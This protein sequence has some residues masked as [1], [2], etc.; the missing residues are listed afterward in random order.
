MLPSHTTTTT[1][2]TTAS[3]SD[4]AATPVVSAAAMQTAH[5]GH[6]S[7]PRSGHDD[8][9]AHHLSKHPTSA[10]VDKATT[11]DNTA[12]PPT[13]PPPPPLEPHSSRLPDFLY[14]LSFCPPLPNPFL[15][16]LAF[17]THPG[18]LYLVG[19]LSACLAGL[20][21]PSLDLLYGLWTNGITPQDASPDQITG[22][23]DLVAWIMALVGLGMFLF[24][25]LFLACFSTA[26]H[27]LTQRLRHAYVSAT[28]A[29]DASHFDLHGAGEIAAR[30]GK[31]ISTIRVGFGEK[32]GYAVWSTAV[33][34]CSVI[35]GFVKS[36]R[37]AGVLFALL[38]FTMILF[39]LMAYATERVGV[40]ALRIEGRASTF[41][42]QILSSVRVVQS[43]GMEASLMRRFDSAMLKPLEKLGMRKAAI[44]GME[45]GTVYFVLNVTYA[46]AFW[47]GSINLASGE[48]DL[49]SLL[50]TFW[51]YLNSL[52]ALSNMVPHIAAIFDSLVALKHVRSSIERVPKI[53]VRDPSGLR[54]DAAGEGDGQGWEPSLELRRVTF[55]YPSRPSVASLDDVSISFEP[56]K[57][58]ALVGP[59]GSGKST[60][61][62]L[63]LREYDP[64]TSNV[65]N[66]SDEAERL[67]L[68]REETK[69]RKRQGIDRGEGEDDRRPSAAE[70]GEK[71]Q[72]GARD[73]SER[74]QGSGQV[75]FGGRDVREINLTWLRSQMA[76]VQQNPQLF[77]ASIFENVAAGLTGTEFAYSPP[78]EV[79]ASQEGGRGAEETAADESV[80]AARTALIREKCR[81]A[82]EKAQAWDFVSQLPQGMDTVVTGGRTGLL[83]GGQ[84]QRVAIARALVRQPRVLCLDEGTSALDS[85]TEEKIKE[86][87]QREQEERGMTTIIIAHRLS[88]I[89]HAD[90]IVTM[91]KGRV[92]DFGTHQELMSPGREPT[93][94]NMVLQQS[95]VLGGD[96]DDDEEERKEEEEEEE[97]GVRG[98]VA[99]NVAKLGQEEGDDDREGRKG[100]EEFIADD[101]TTKVGGTSRKSSSP[102]Q[103]RSPERRPQGTKA[104]AANTAT[105]KNLASEHQ[106]NLAARSTSLS[107]LEHKAE[108]PAS[109]ALRHP[110]LGTAAGSKGGG[111]GGDGG[112]IKHEP[113]EGDRGATADQ[114]EEDKGRRPLRGAFLRYV[115]S[116]KTCFAIGI[117]GALM[118]GASFP[119]AGWM[120]GGAVNSLSIQGDDGRLR[121]EANLWS[122]YFVILA[123]ADLIIILI[124][125]FFLEVASEQVV[126]RLKKDGLASL[127]RQ[128]ISFFDSEENASGSLSSAVSSHPAN[129]GAATGLILSQVI[130]SMA[131]LV[132]SII[133]ALALSWKAA[134]VVLAPI[135]FI[136]ASGWANVIMLERYEAIAQRPVDRAASYI[137]ENVDAIRTVAALGREA[138]T[139]RIFS[140]RSRS[141]PAR[142]RYLIFG[143]GGFALSQALV[144]LL[145]SLTFYWGGQLLSKGDLGI[146]QLYAVFEAVIIGAFAGGRLF[147]FVPDYGRAS[148]SFKT[149]ASWISREPKVAVL[150]PSSSR[151]SSQASPVSEEVDAERSGE[152]KGQ[153]DPSVRQLA[154]GDIVFE[155]V[156]LR[157]PS[158]PEHAA[159][160]GLDLRISAGQTVA[161]CGT[162]GS[163]KSST[164]SLL[165]RFYDPSRGRITMGGVDVR[166]IDLCE[167]RSQMA[168]VSQEPV[169]YEGT[170]G[171]N[172][173]LGSAESA[174]KR[175]TIDEMEKACQE[176]CILDFVRSLP[177]GFETEVGFKG[178]QLS[179]GQ[180]Q[181][182]CIAR[183]LI[184]RPS[185]LLLDEATSALDSESEL[186]VQRA[187]ENASR[188]RT[189]ITVA[190]RL[191]TIQRSDLICVVEDG[192]IREM[193]THQQLLSLRQR[194]LELVQAQL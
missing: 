123:S 8:E 29:Q 118:A 96:E 163:G 140:Q 129:V 69:R 49:G 21:M 56:G 112:R 40:P 108:A 90:K 23:S 137:A 70:L 87:L 60:I 185:I 178:A 77:T 84:R 155:D 58:T 62:G 18:V 52:F 186:W 133:L 3:S 67:V 127:I 43:F 26:S 2:T 177:K 157:Y 16:P 83:S 143:S 5:Q 73:P 88:T 176:A 121:H 10:G 45:M 66:Q 72:G 138:E 28:L 30:A 19:T 173:S 183:A 104:E 139:M 171:W 81:V 1:T 114:D 47:W 189:T 32:L 126:R 25:W 79:D 80:K 119:L 150:E 55:A 6:R 192:R 109:K 179:G 125:S 13:P 36:A 170:I 9:G 144:V 156:E 42:E 142:T 17:A 35:I 89:R 131:N 166:A 94:R 24:C 106:W 57:V 51:N 141:E 54:L 53:D 85:S 107:Q 34:V 48:V 190:H 22:R 159:L 113:K 31:D 39:S 128:E 33:L 41:L 91:S 180:K 68:Q 120:T 148:N 78:D 151:S 181:R 93:Y 46:L 136:F 102:A 20:G 149:I 172:L 97:D 169:L 161:F 158:R 86:A 37:I 100:R 64:E 101:A 165:Q 75:L 74:V 130:I 162:S 174:T 132:G 105:T 71:V 115:W 124:N 65:P 7:S 11:L 122:L 14:L 44:R 99:L 12:I 95:N 4:Q 175:T 59:S 145:A 134:L 182:L 116:Q 160:R 38:P 184:R 193:G 63:L 110:V 147:T 82:L 50:T 167:L 117:C 152:E 188:G 168:Y 15:S 103:E 92:V 164:L 76:V 111:N 194:Y 191:S 154:S 61:A 27:D 187:L 153:P 98:S 146:T 135:L